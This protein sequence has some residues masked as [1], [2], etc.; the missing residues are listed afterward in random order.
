M[1]LNR[2][3]QWITAAAATV[4]AIW[5]CIASSLGDLAAALKPERIQDPAAPDDPDKDSADS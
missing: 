3:W 2:L 4:T 5:Q 1:R